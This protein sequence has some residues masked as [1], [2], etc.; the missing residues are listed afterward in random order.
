[1]ILYSAQL[2]SVLS[3]H[4]KIFEMRNPYREAAQDSLRE[5]EAVD[6][7]LVG[8]G[9]YGS[10]LAEYCLRRKKALLGVD[11]DPDPL[12]RWCKRAVPVLYGD[13]ADPEMLEQ[14]PLNKARWLISTVRSKELNLMLLNQLRRRGYGGKVALTA[15]NEQEA[16]AFQHAGAHL[17]FCPFKDATEQA[18]D[19]LTHAMD[20]LPDSLDWPISFLELRVRS[21]ASAAGKT[22]RELSLSTT[23]ISILAVSRGGLVH[24]SPQPDFRIFPGDRLLLTGP[25]VQ[26]MRPSRPER[27]G[28]SPCFSN[29]IHAGCSMTRPG[30]PPG[31][32]PTTTPFWITTTGPCATL[33]N[34][35]CSTGGPGWRHWR[36]FGAASTILSGKSRG[37]LNRSAP[38]PASATRTCP[39]RLIGSRRS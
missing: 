9:S 7:I 11:F 30:L 33:P 3:G 34:W 13:I 5:T 39:G 20:F 37:W 31:G 16:Q 35:N 26:K 21:D 6:M 32:V 12:D 17:V 36:P 29:R 4:L 10:G 38:W 8:L 18:A 25:P 2:Y 27:F 23:G 24:D 15:I 1:M 28:E 19:A 14:L 22:I